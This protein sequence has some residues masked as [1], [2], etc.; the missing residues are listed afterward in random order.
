MQA[1]ITQ[2]ILLRGQRFDPSPEPIELEAEAYLNL[3]KAGCV[4]SV[5]ERRVRADAEA[6]AVELKAATDKQLADQLAAVEQQAKAD[7]AD[8]AAKA[9]SEAS[10][11][12]APKRKRG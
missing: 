1:F 8:A 3:R 11:E 5:D 12:A 7:A 4:E 10:A 6:M 9:E 2:G